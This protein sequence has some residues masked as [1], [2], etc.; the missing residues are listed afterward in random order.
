MSVL[1]HDQSSLTTSLSY[2]NATIKDPALFTAKPTDSK[3]MSLK[4]LDILTH[5]DEKVALVGRKRCIH[6]VDDADGDPWSGVRRIV[7]RRRLHEPGGLLAVLTKI[8]PMD[9]RK[10]PPRDREVHLDTAKEKSAV[11][12]E[13]VVKHFRYEKNGHT[14]IVKPTIENI[15]KCGFGYVYAKA[16]TD[17][18][19]DL[20]G[21][22]KQEY[23]EVIKSYF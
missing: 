4:M 3:A 17:T 16:F 19:A 14:Y 20:V 9:I 13:Y 12:K 23:D 22:M 1:G 15:M 10:M 6:D 7:R 2:T 11:V 8:P 5:I 21:Q 18:E